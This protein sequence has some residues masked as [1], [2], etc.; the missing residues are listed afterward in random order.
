MRSIKKHTEW[1]RCARPDPSGT[2][3]ASCSN[4]QTVRIWTFD[5]GSEKHVMN[6]HTHVVSALLAF[7]GL[8]LVES[9]F[10]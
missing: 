10:S 5:N 4:D 3:I 6:K 1:V 2:L 9:A 8:F 7:A